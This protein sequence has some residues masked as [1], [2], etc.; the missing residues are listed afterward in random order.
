MPERVFVDTSAILSFISKTDS[1]HERALKTFDALRSS[2]AS[3]VTT[4]YVLVE[5]YAL[6]HRR[7]GKVAARRFREEFSPILEVIWV[8][9]ALHE[10][11]LELFL[12]SPRSISLV[13]AASFVSIR[14]LGVE[15]VWAIDRHFDDEGFDVLP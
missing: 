11:A 1:S 7:L 10:R 5:T 4:S 12:G 6:L 8:N 14:D 13:D 15:K 9:Q 2:S 3:L